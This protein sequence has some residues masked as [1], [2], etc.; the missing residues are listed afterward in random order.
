MTQP[1]TNNNKGLYIAGAFFACGAAAGATIR[2]L[3]KTSAWPFGTNWIQTEQEETEAAGL[4]E[5]AVS[6]SDSDQKA[7][8]FTFDDD[9]G[10]DIS[11]VPDDGSVF[12]KKI[13]SLYRI[14]ALIYAVALRC[15]NTKTKPQRMVFRKELSDQLAQF[16]NAE[17]I[18]K[19]RKN[20]E[21]HALHVE[22]QEHLTRKIK[23]I[24]SSFKKATLV[25]FHD[26]DS[27]GTTPKIESRLK[28]YRDFSKHST[29]DA[30]ILQALLFALQIIN[31]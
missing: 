1:N 17:F 22:I 29:S 26:N 21:N 25:G 4:D 18:Q 8:S 12:S 27:A 13:F 24:L 14:L 31:D 28:I 10:D 23:A 2:G 19:L 3:G 16:W 6:P 5:A 15:Y 20:I 30:S 11:S 7:A 9:G